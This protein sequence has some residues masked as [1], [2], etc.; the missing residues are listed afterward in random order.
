MILRF[1]E[2]IR[3]VTWTLFTIDVDGVTVPANAATIN[4]GRTVELTLTTP[5]TAP[6]AS[7]TVALAVGA[8]LD[9]ASNGNLALAATAVTNAVSSPTPTARVLVSNVGQTA[10]DVASTS[11]NEHGQ[12]FHTAANTGTN[13]GGWTLTSVIVVTENTNEFDVEICA[14]DGA[15]NL[16]DTAD[17]TALTA[18]SNFISGNNEFTHAGLS[19]SANANYLVVID[20]RGAHATNDSV[21]VDS[22]TSN[23]EDSGGV[24][25]WSIKERFAWN[26]AGTWADKG[27]SAEALRIT[28]NGYEGSPVVFTP[29]QLAPGSLTASLENG[30]VRLNWSA[31][32]AD[33]ASVTGYAIF[34]ANPQLT[35]AQPFAIYVSN[36]GNTDTTYLDEA[37]IAGTRNSYR[38]AAWRG[39]VASTNSNN[40]F[41]D[42]PVPSVSS[43]VLTSNPGLDN[44][45]SIGNTVRA[46][47]TFSAAV[48][49]TGSPQLELNFD[50]SAKAAGCATGTDTTTM[51]CSYTVLVND[52]APDGIAI[53][54]NK[55]T[56][57]TITATGA[58]TAADLD[59]SAVVFQVAHKVDGIRPTLVTTGSDAPKTSADGAKIILTF[60]EN[61]SSPLRARII[62]KSGTTVLTSTAATATGAKV[63]VTLATA[64][65][66]ASASLTVELSAGA[67]EDTP[68]S[69]GNLALAATTVINAVSSTPTVTEVALTSTPS[70][71]RSAYGI[72]EDIEAT[73]TFSAAVDI[74][75]SPR[76]EL[77]FD[78][79]AKSA[80]C[81]TGTNT[82]TT[83][84]AY[85][86]AV[87]DSAPDGIAIG[88]NKL[89]G[90]TIHF[91]GDA[92]ETA[93]RDHSAVAADSGHKVDGSRPTLVRTG[94]NAPT[95]STDGT[96]VILVFSEDIGSVDRTKITIGATMSGATTSGS[97]VGSLSTG[98]RLQLTLATPLLSTSENIT[99][100]LGAGAVEDVAGNGNLARSATGVSNVVG[101][102][103]LDPSFPST[104][105]GMREVAE[106]NVENANV[107]APVSATDPDPGDVL[108]YSLSGTD[109]ASFTI[110]SSGQISVATGVTLDYEGKKSYRVTVQVSDRQDQDDLEDL[111]VDDTQRVTITVTNVNEAPVV[112]GP[113]TA[114]IKENASS[115]L[116]TYRATDPEGDKVFWAVSA[117][118]NFWISDGGQALLPLA[119]ELRGPGDVLADR[120]RVGRHG[121]GVAQRDRHRRERGG[122]GCRDA[123]PASRLGGHDVHGRSGRRRRRSDR[124]FLGVG[125]VLRP[126]KLDEPLDR[127]QRV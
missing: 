102:L 88:A 7:L 120:V 100:A 42:V 81:T 121:G 113:G 85:F 67:V 86:V 41:V 16:P 117:P 38:V 5:I 22:T 90:G 83:K 106:N 118:A 61:I 101:V 108:T 23:G 116:A 96:Q 58:T 10:D 92:T 19:L 74:S 25:G 112:T 20:Q 63:E 115:V 54:A 78:G 105:T 64:L 65:T 49:I 37:P 97:P 29:A 71:G 33:A 43:V 73:V 94:A 122:A 62:I 80:G 123:H 103:N 12:L 45:Y 57:G 69:N 104:E 30:S 119:A 91:T 75:G 28:V 48:D 79:A 40:A 111:S 4:S 60:S 21:S 13:T 99:V 56:G 124:P 114:S 126:I 68:G 59:H 95:T 84:C 52:S 27:G 70:S 2:D 15:T 47:V 55:L 51:V 31:P 6:S 11:G 66:A 98:T 109:A 93:D 1:S 87:G 35:P 34:R 24:T 39:S 17:C 32:E 3:L 18:P 46:T 82:T 9:T 36:T 110:D 72:G 50:G 127:H 14:E 77:D 26:N 107:G 125:A 76:L 8:V 53:G 44:T 89:T